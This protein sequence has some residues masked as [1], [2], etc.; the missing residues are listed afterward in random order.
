MSYLLD[1]NV[2]SEIRKRS[3]DPGVTKWFD[4]VDEEELFLSVLVVGEIR[5]G[6]TRLARHN[7]VGAKALERWLWR[8]GDAYRD[9]VLPV[10][11]EIAETWGQLNVPDPLPAV[12]G[13]LA[14]TALVRRF[15]LV[16]RNTC[17]VARTGVQLLNPFAASA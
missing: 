3:P 10:T 12:D 17:D 2:V 7:E 4:S 9:R 13:L 6:I 16:T 8:L 14:A 11:A 1:T 15:T 5:Q